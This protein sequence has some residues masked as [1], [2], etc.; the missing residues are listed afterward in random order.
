[1]RTSL[2]IALIILCL[3]CPVTLAAQEASPLNLSGTW[4]MNPS[5]SKM[6]KWSHVQSETIVIVQNGNESTS[7]T[8]LTGN[9]QTNNSL[10]TRKNGR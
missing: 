9:S 7:T 4:K 6:P 10:L 2:L 1:M 3:T 5:R 8:T